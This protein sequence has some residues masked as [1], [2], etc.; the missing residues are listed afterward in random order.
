M[1]YYYCCLNTRLDNETTKK[2]QKRKRRIWPMT[3]FSPVKCAFDGIRRY[4]YRETHTTTQGYLSSALV[5]SQT[6]VNW[7]SAMKKASRDLPQGTWRQGQPTWPPVPAD[8]QNRRINGS[9]LTV[10]RLRTVELDLWEKLIKIFQMKFFFSPLVTAFFFGDIYL[11]KSLIDL[12]GCVCSCV[13]L[14][15]PL[16]FVLLFL[17]YFF[18]LLFRFYL[19]FFRAAVCSICVC[20]CL[21][22]LSL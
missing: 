15:L 16:P 4:V 22:A 5:L 9:L 17:F 18:V 19:F 20:F 11:K 13:Y 2:G 21:F 6:E 10:V 8:K 14:C 1:C 3:R 12:V 7:S